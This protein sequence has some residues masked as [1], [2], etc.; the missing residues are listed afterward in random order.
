MLFTEKITSLSDWGAIF[1]KKEAFVPLAE[2]IF[3]QCGLPFPGLE[4]CTPG[5]NAVFRA[6]R[7]IV[8]IFAPE[9]SRIGGVGEFRAETYGLERAQRLGVPAPRILASGVLRDR[10]VF[11]WLLLEA[12]EGSSLAEAAEKLPTDAWYAV[13]R[14]L[15]DMVEKLDTPCTALCGGR[16]RGPLAEARW[17]LFPESFRQERAAFLENWTPET[18]FVHGDLNADNLM[19]APGNRLYA[20]DF[21]DCRTAPFETELAALVCD[22]F[23]FHPHYLRGVLGEAD[24]EQTAEAL[25]RGLLLHDYGAWIIRDRVAVPGTLHTLD[26]LK[27][28]LLCCL[29]R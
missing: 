14:Q 25:V 8:K 21:A 15:R 2:E 9:E 3:R 24:R 6:G 22:G 10:Y 23:R 26:H 28:S 7:H 17:A 19:V 4:N 27:R 29:N 18:V 11:R 20:I 1:Q 16:L 12:I 13:G 5:S